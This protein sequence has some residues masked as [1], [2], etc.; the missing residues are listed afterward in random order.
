[1]SSFFLEIALT[2]DDEHRQIGPF[3]SY[4]EARA[5]GKSFAEEGLDVVITRSEI[6]CD[7]CSSPHPIKRLI[8]DDIMVPEAE[9][10]SRGDWAACEFCWKII[11]SDM[12]VEEK[13]KKLASHSVK[14]AVE[15]YRLPNDAET[16]FLF[17]EGVSMIQTAFFKAWTGEV[18]DV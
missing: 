5:R 13:V 12:A 1:V 14:R 15:M 8:A 10:A 3:G 6:I 9:W 16:V 2:K 17:G 11:S 18:Q 7:F 4:A